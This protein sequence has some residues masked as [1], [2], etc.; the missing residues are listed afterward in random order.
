MVIRN[1]MFALAGLGAAAPAFAGDHVTCDYSG[2]HC[3]R[4]QDG[5]DLSWYSR[6]DSDD[7]YDRGRHV[8]CDPDGDRCYLSRSWRW[9]YRQYYR[10]HGY[11]WDN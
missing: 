6:Y 11:R 4:A 7:V 8:V 2:Y 10:L 9:N 3:Y 1:L 5:R